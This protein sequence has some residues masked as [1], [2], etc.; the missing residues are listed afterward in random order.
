[1]SYLYPRNRGLRPLQIFLLLAAGL[2][3]G[4]GVAFLLLAPR[5]VSVAPAAGARVGSFAAV[6]IRFSV[7]MGA[8]CTADHFSVDPP[9][10]GDLTV[11]GDTLRFAPAAPWPEGAAVRV[12]VRGG[13]CSGR[14]LPLLIGSAWSFSPALIRIA[15]IPAAA[16]D[17]LLGVDAGGGDPELLAQV[18]APIQ[19]YD[20]S[21]RGDFAVLATGA[22]GHPG[23]L[24]TSPLA[25]GDAGLLLDCGNDACRDPEISPDGKSVAYVRQRLD[26]PNTLPPQIELLTLSDKSTRL[27]SPAGDSAEN[28][29]WSDQ[30]WLSYYDGARQV[31]VADDLAGGQTFLPDST[32]LPWTW[33]P[34]GSAIVFPET[35]VQPGAESSET[36]PRLYNHL[37]AVAVKTNDRKDLSGV[38]IIDETLPVFSP[39]GRW[40]VFTRSFFDDR[41]TPGRQLWI[42][43]WR[44]SSIRQLTDAPDYSHSSIH[45]SPDGTRLVFM[46]FHET[47]PS[48][49]PEIWTLG[50]DGSDPRRLAVGGFLP[51]WLP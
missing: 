9:V 16:D 35:L 47:S 4:L 36:A 5:I 33:L 19:S 6:E 21:Q 17:T 3:L 40:L 37:F 34:D 14:G 20:I 23:Q 31:I 7:P 46:M 32:G 28:P 48:D 26:P 44:E 42:M 50:V 38:E 39:D 13:A 41:W 8:A 29:T 24:W 30:G 45:W 10:A 1:M 43:D 11:Q 15:Y 18:P 27:I 49:P 2:A 25:G 51:Q 12:A 22:A